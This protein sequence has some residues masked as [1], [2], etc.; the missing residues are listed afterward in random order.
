[1]TSHFRQA[2]ETYRAGLLGDVLPFWIRHGVDREHGGVITSLDRDGTTLDTDKAIWAQG[3]F[4]WLLATLYHTVEPREEWLSIARE[5]LTFIRRHG[6]DADGRLFFLVT[7]DGRPLRKRRYVYSEAFATMA[8]AAYARAAQDDEAAAEARDLFR[9]FLRYTTT[10]GLLEPKVFPQT[11]ASKSFTVPM[12]TLSVAQVLRETLGDDLGEPSVDAVIDRCI[13]E[14]RRDFLKPELEAVMETVGPGGELLDHFDGRLL[15]PGHAIE[16]AWFILHEA[17]HRGGD[18]DL[19]K[20]GTTMLD[21]MWHRGW[22]DEH[23]GLFYY[24]DAKGLPVQEY[25][26]DMKF[27]WPHC[28]AIIATL[29]A[30][31]L[32]G[33]VRYARWHRQV[34]DWT[35]AHFPDPDVGEWYGYLHRDGRPSVPLKGNWWKGPYHIPRMQWYGWRLLED[36]EKENPNLLDLEVPA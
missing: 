3:R 31:A 34:H 21:W 15:N 4:A 1:M 22:D 24:R 14:I 20:L 27:W 32:T 26:H 9:R 23:G 25:W 36:V 16:A 29:L 18:A 28:E 33:E 2:K 11:R 13:D 5:T 17:R 30:Y 6:F 19:V 8:F 7:R 12:I 35:Y 10:P